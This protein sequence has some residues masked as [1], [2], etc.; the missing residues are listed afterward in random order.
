[1]FLIPLLFP[2]RIIKKLKPSTIPK[3]ITLKKRKRLTSKRPRA[4]E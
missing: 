4:A 2:S 1:M 3:M